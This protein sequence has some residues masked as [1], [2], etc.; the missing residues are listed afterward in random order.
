MH[1]DRHIDCCGPDSGLT[2]DL[3][4]RR[5]SPPINHP[6]HVPRKQANFRGQPGEKNKLVDATISGGKMPMLNISLFI[7]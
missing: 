1:T 7:P 2:Q 4:I 6:P 5:A 3:S